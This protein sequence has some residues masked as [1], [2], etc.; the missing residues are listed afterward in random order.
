MVPLSNEMQIHSQNNKITVCFD[1]AVAQT[2]RYMGYINK[3]LATDNQR[4][5][6]CII[7]THEDQNLVNAISMVPDID[8]YRYNLNFSL[9]RIDFK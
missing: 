1:V 7:G 5:K 9:D 3:T 4:V 2:L 6:G 8:F